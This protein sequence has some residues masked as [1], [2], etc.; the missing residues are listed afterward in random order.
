MQEVQKRREDDLLLSTIHIFWPFP[1]QL[2]E[3]GHVSRDWRLFTI[4][5]IRAW[6][7]GFQNS[8]LRTR[9]WLGWPLLWLFL[10]HYAHAPTPLKILRVKFLLLNVNTELQY[11]TWQILSKDFMILWWIC[12]SDTMQR[13]REGERGHLR[14]ISQAGKSKTRK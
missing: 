3:R 10:W 2:K 13:E 7:P 6:E 8:H 12:V 9:G 4:I 11:F 1:A 14:L 5:E